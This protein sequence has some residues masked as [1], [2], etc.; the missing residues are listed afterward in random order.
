MAS[1]QLSD[2]KS[3]PD[4]LYRVSANSSQFVEWGGLTVSVDRH[5]LS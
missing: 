2:F 4:T 5:D 3:F 1:A